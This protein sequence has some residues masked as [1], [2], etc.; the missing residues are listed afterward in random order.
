MLL[1][2][3]WIIGYTTAYTQ[4]GSA[5][6]LSWVGISLMFPLL[7]YVTKKH[8]KHVI[9]YWFIFSISVIY[10]NLYEQSNA[11]LIEVSNTHIQTGKNLKLQG[12]IKTPPEIDGDRV[13]FTLS[14]DV[15]EFMPQIS[16]K[17]KEKLAVQLTLASEDEIKIARAWQRGDIIALSGTLE[18]PNRATNFEGFNYRLYLQKQGIHWIVKAKGASAVTFIKNESVSSLAFLAHIDRLRQHIGSIIDELFPDWQ[19]GYMKG[20]LIG[21][22]D[23]LSPDKYKQ[24]TN[25]GMTH[26][27]AISGSHVAINI[28][29][30]FGLLRL[31]KVTRE[32]AYSTVFWLLP[33]YVLM[34][35]FS[36]SVVRAGL[37]TMLGIFLLKKGLF[38][39]GLNILSAVGL[40][41]LI[42]QPY[43]LFNISFQLSFAVTAGII[44][45][46]PFI[47][48]YIVWLPAKIRG[49]IAITIAAEFIS[50]PLTLY[51]FNQY[52]LLSMLANFALVPIISAVTLP[53]GTISLLLGALWIPL[54][55]WFAYVV[56]GVNVVT[57]SITKWLS[58]LSGFMTYWKSPSALWLC[59]YYVMLYMMFYLLHRRKL[60]I[61][62]DVRSY[63]DTVP[64]EGTTISRGKLASAHVNA[65]VN[66]N[67]NRVKFQHALKAG[68]Y[69]LFIGG[70]VA[71]LVFAY[72]PLNQKGIGHVQF[73]DV[74]Q[75]DCILITTPTGVNILIDGGGTVSFRKPKDAW[76][77]RRSPYEVGEKTVVPL[78]KKRG[79]HTLDIVIMTHADQDHIGG[80]QAVLSHFPVRALV[81]N[82]SLTQSATLT[83]LL[84]TA[85]EKNIPIY[86]AYR[87]MGL[88]LDPLTSI[89]FIFPEA[90]I[91]NTMPVIKDQNH[92]SIVFYLKMDGVRFLFTGDMD[93]ASENAIMD[94]EKSPERLQADV[95]KVA[96]HGSKTS[97][98]LNWLKAIRPKLTVIPVG[99][100]N[101][102]GHPYP[103]VIQQ[104]NNQGVPIYRTDQ[105]GEVQMKVENG[106]LS[107]RTYSH[108][109]DK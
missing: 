33:I 68:R 88:A 89:D 36:P 19:G 52:S 45:F 77:T 69:A 57:F 108:K 63:D 42:W 93:I 98:S 76:R 82:G 23:D 39:D 12:V 102:Y 46:T 48:P 90:R 73:I 83:K 105:N 20:L 49:G 37:M 2:C 100:R 9:I 1:V 11:S 94:L 91:D 50:F 14:A 40:I 54:G 55:K 58:E 64:L 51:Y 103:K 32:R 15:I 7:G 56:Q 8:W 16:S 81:M 30:V 26:I 79:I 6:W 71:M 28:S 107:L 62:T 47:E 44:I 92:E 60:E 18:Q 74:G 53:V 80:L 95:L 86:S 104:I 29:L 43:Y 99:S 24:F 17:D 97:T 85:L 70:F 87:G 3:L 27:L 21:V 22:T 59:V 72:Q 96:H 41:M 84:E 25:L 35:G 65:N 78:L 38:K 34:T 31:L 106:Q 66:I 13:G 101:S 61:S 75:G 4:K 109:Y 10:W 5:C 67:I